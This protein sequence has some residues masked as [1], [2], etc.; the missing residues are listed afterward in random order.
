MRYNHKKIQKFFDDIERM[1][2]KYGVKVIYDSSELVYAKGEK[3]GCAGYFDSELR[4]LKIAN[5]KTI[6]DTCAIMA[7][8]SSHMDQWIQDRYIW[9][10]LAPGYALFFEWLNGKICKREH[11][12]ESVQDIIRLELDCEKRAVAKIKRYGLP[13]NI[14]VYK[15]RANCYLYGYLYFLEKRKW[16]PKLYDKKEIWTI[17]P[18]KFPSKH[19]TIPVRLRAK[20]AQYPHK[21]KAGM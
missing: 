16:I 4:V 1:A 8:E 9:D 14:S 15:K 13:V 6:S 19:I 5:H 2:N 10:K 17:A 3:E 20:F 21:N 18:D 7:H 12:E 11:L